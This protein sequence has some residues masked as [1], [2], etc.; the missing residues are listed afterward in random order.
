MCMCACLYIQYMISVKVSKAINN[1]NKK[2][3]SWKKNLHFLHNHHHHHKIDKRKNSFLILET[4]DSV[5][6]E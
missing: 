6:I 2:K 1:N 5:E 4:Q 3:E